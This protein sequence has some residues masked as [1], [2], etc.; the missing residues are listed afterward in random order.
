MTTHHQ[1]LLGR[2]ATSAARR[3]RR[4]DGFQELVAQTRQ[5]LERELAA[6]ESHVEAARVERNAAEI[7]YRQ[8]EA[9]AEARRTEIRRR[10]ASL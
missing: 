1:G 3:M 10:L 6:L 7:R 2:I 4:R 9:Q 5:Q 8:R